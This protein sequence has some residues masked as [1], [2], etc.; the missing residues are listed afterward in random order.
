MSLATLPTTVRTFARLRV[1]A[2]VLSKHGFG[3]FVERLQLGGYLPSMEFLRRGKPV[4]E[5]EADPLTAIGTR[6]VRVCEELGPTFVKLGQL[7]STRPDILPPQILACLERLQDEVA[8]FPSIDARRIFEEDTGSNVSEAFESFS[9]APLASGSIAQAHRAKTKDHREVVVK[10]K[11]PG[12]EH[13]VQLDIYV[14]R[15]IA[16]RAD[17]LFPELRPYRPKMLADEFAESIRRELDFINEASVTSRFH[18]AFREHPHVRT[19]QVY[20]ELTG[21]NVLTIEFMDGL[22]LR[23]ILEGKTAECDRPAV[24]R[25]LADCFLD[26]YFE[27]GLFHADPHP[28]NLLIRPPEGISLFD[29]GLVGSLDDELVGQLVF[30]IIAAVNKEIEVLIDVLADM[31]ALSRETNRNVLARDL[32]QW[33]D[34]YY[35]LPIRR[36]DLGTVFREFIETVRRNDVTLTREL[37]TLIKSLATGWGV[38][39][40]LDPELNLLDLLRPKLSKLM[41]ERLAPRR[42]LRMAGLSTWHLASIVRDAP[43]L[44]R[45]LMRGIGRGQ[46]QVNIRHE[47]L[48]HLAS[49]L[50]RSSNRL[51]FSVLVASTIIGSTMLLG[52]QTDIP[53]IGMPIRYLGFL[54]YALTFCMSAWLLI[55]ILRSGKMS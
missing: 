23:D 35:G 49:E 48:D 18:D 30:A 27:L 19:P 14:L 8:P 33:L 47:N 15:W 28:G 24:A 11:R 13:V 43:R 4:E 34:K 46:F 55:A 41:R 3:H 36:L 25:H 38:V 44:I 9:D 2:Q 12:I 20:W 53:I 31:G 52:M 32:R 26:Q 22:R 16:E 51:A 50:D 29:F 37:V 5:V 17:A 40:Q 6:L 45:D 10:I 42:L 21:A 7:A 54:G 39:L 1:I